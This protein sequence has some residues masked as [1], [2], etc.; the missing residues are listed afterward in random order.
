MIL[1]LGLFAIDRL[2]SAI[3]EIRINQNPF[4]AQYDDVYHSTEGGLAQAQHVFLGGNGLPGAWQGKGAFTIVET[5]S[6]SATRWPIY[7][8][9]LRGYFKEVGLEVEFAPAPASNGVM[10]QLASGSYPMG[11][12]SPIDALRAIDKG[13]PISMLRIES[14]QAPYEVFARKSIG[15]L[16]DLRGKTIMVDA[17]RGGIFRGD[18]AE[19]EMRDAVLA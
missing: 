12:G 7:G 4:S 3:Q 8:A 5:G 18:T 16:A 2:G 10:Q 1:A 14:A 6:G 9:Q 19:I 17:A 11:A 15:K 13:A